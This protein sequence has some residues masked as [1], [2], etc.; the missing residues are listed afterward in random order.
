MSLQK[1]LLAL[2][3]LTI[4]STVSSTVCGSNPLLNTFDITAAFNEAKIVPGIIYCKSLQNKETCCSADTINGFQAKADTLI[5]RLTSAV[6]KRDQSLVDIRKNVIPN[7]NG[8]LQ[9]MKQASTRAVAKLQASLGDTKTGESPDLGSVMMNALVMGMVQAYGEMAT[10]LTEN[11]STMR[12]N[13]TDFQKDRTA[14]VV[15]IVKIQAAAWC[16]A[17][18]PEFTSKG[19][20]YEGIEFSTNLKQTLTDSCFNYFSGSAMQSMI[21][22]INLI[23]SSL[24][25]ITSAMNK[26]ARG[27]PN[28]ATEFMT[29]I[30]TS[31]VS[32]S[33]MDESSIPISFPGD[34]DADECEWIASTLFKGGKLDESS[35]SMGGSVGESSSG[36]SSGSSSSSGSGSFGFDFGGKRRLAEARPKR[37]LT[38]GEWDPDTDEAGVSVTFEDN[39]GNVDNSSAMLFKS[40]LGGLIVLLSVLLI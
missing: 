12:N 26:I 34:C 23:G 21:F 19:V 3:I 24:S 13:F 7:L 30:M 4:A 17:C 31:S 11:L 36:S 9:S 25:G 32:S 18:D 29:A 22:S 28:G 5:K 14:C 15:D 40:I 38:E 37:I 1:S 20:S 27:D 16:L 39:P 8:K 35:L 33:S 10:M 2:L 6:G